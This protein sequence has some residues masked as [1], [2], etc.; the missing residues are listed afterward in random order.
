MVDRTY[1]SFPVALI[2]DGTQVALEA[3]IPVSTSID[4]DQQTPS[5]FSKRS[6]VDNNRQSADH[7]IIRCMLKC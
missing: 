3:K 7:S 1:F 5:R 2:P 6:E 4:C